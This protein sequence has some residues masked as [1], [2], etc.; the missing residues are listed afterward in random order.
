M[1]PR[2]TEILACL[3]YTDSHPRDAV[4]FTPP[5]VAL[6]HAAGLSG[7]VCQQLQPPNTITSLPTSAAG[8][9]TGGSYQR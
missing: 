6:Q 7:L 1:C 8:I 2:C 9:S 3:L 4:K 5:G